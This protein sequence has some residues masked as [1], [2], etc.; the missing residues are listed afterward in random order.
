MPESY[1]PP[2]QRTPVEEFRPYRVARLIDLATPAADAHIVSDIGGATGSWRWTGQRPAVKVT[3]KDT[4][5][6][7]YFI[8]FAVADATFAQ[9][10]PVTVTFKVNDH[11]LE[12]VPY[13]QPGNQHFEKL[14]PAEWLKADDDTIVSAEVDKV[15]VS[16]E[17]GAQLGLVLMKLGLTQ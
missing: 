4:Q 13:A 10:G 16:P 9:T 7:K 15:F 3:L 1:A 2:I 8:D 11:V 14:V 17:D 6:V 5:N 12:S